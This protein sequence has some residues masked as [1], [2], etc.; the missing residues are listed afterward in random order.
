MA[1]RD[2][3]GLACYADIG[4]ANIAVADD[5][6]Q[7]ELRGVAGDRKTDA[8]RA[9][10]DRGIDTDHLSR[11]RHQRPAGISGVERSISLDHVLDGPPAHRAD[12]A[13]ERRH[14]AGRHSRFKAER[15]TYRDHELAA[16]Q[17]L[18]IAER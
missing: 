14:D 9:I 11:R 5:L 8:L 2:R 17:A 10:D 16:A 15:I 18:G 7:H 6:G 3:R 4:A 1:P 13:A 12:R